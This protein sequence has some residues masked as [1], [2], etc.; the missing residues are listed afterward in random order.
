[1]VYED[2][3]QQ[4]SWTDEEHKKYLMFLSYHLSNNHSIGKKNPRK[5][6]I[7]YLEKKN[8]SNSCHSL[9][10]QEI[11]SSVGRIIRN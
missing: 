10:E 2:G 6:L 3:L 4:G 9:L 5:F 11:Y 1:M 8:Y 7:F